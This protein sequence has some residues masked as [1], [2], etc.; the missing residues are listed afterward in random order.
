MGIESKRQMLLHYAVSMIGGFLGGYAIIN[1]S[2]IFGNAQTANLIHLVTKIFSGELSGIVFLTL[3]LA[4]YMAGN[5]FC[6]I[7]DK[8]FKVD[9]R[10]ISLIFTSCTVVIIGL[11]PSVANDY[12]AVLPILFVT[13]IQWN[14]FR[15]AN[16]YISSTIFSTNNLRQ[17]TT[18]LAS[19]LIDR[20]E[21]QRDKAKF[22]W[23]TLASFHVGV[24]LSCV[25]SFVLGVN[26]IWFCFIPIMLAAAAYVRLE[27]KNIGFVNKNVSKA[28]KS[29]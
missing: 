22:F 21:K 1:H 18:S 17:A 20:D 2:D 29:I 11:F 5:I 10:I 3:S 14:A 24:A 19:Y 27:Q 6:V 28:E 7:A 13:P 8:F 4:T 25:S 9:L 23:S 26:S 15:E 16:G 12:I